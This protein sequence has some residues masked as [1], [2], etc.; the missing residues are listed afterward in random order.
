MF[1][2]FKDVTHSHVIK[3]ILRSRVLDTNGVPLLVGLVSPQCPSHSA[4]GNV[5]NPW[6]F[7][8]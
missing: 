1:T 4:L 3:I 5:S 8:A 7:C 2:R 6:I